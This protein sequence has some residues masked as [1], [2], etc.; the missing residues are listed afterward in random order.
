MS[1]PDDIRRKLTENAQRRAR[2]ESEISTAR[3]RQARAESDAATAIAKANR[4]TS[5]S[6]AR[7][8]LRAAERAQASVLSE[9]KKLATLSDKVAGH[10]KKDADLNRDLDNA[11]KSAA[12]AEKRER[13]RQARQNK[14]RLAADEAARRRREASERASRAQLD[15]RL[16]AT[17]AAL[18]RLAAPPRREPLRILYVTASS[19]GTL[20]VDHEIR[21]VKAAV[22][23][24]TNRDLID[25]HPLLAATPG[26]LLDE[27]A[28]FRPHVLHFSG[29]AGPDVL[30]FDLDIP[31]RNAGD[32]VSGDLFKRVVGAVDVPP[33]LVVLNACDS[34]SQAST[35]TE[36]VPFAIGMSDEVDDADAILFATRFYSAVAEGQSIRASYDLGRLQMELAGLPGASLPV[37]YT[38]ATADAARVLVLPPAAEGA[39]D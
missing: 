25:V 6:S 31:D 17:D 15:A 26:D 29:H 27:L 34:A 5:E 39:A 33:I 1:S 38:A 22:Q 7:S 9:S 2:V 32:F 8:Y 4:A 28:R 10:A 3:T 20:R 11:L 14:T 23:A 12:A 18:R 30:V 21:R 36:V 13:E 16:D 19:D 37:L 24:A 35:L